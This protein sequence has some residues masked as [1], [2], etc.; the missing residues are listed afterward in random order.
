V[1]VRQFFCDDS[2]QLS[3]TRLLSFVAVVGGTAMAFFFPEYEVGYLGLVTLGFG[4]KVAQKKLSETK[5]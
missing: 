4:G 3:M 1:K 5:K 2:G